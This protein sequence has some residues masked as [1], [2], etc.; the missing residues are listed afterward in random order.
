MAKEIERKFLLDVDKLPSRVI[1]ILYNTKP[2]H[3]EQFYTSINPEI[4][5]R[6]EVVGYEDKRKFTKTEKTKTSKA[7]VRKEKESKISEEEYYDQLNK[8]ETEI[9][10]AVITKNRYMLALENDLWA[11]IDIYSEGAYCVI[12]V[13]FSSVDEA[14]SWIPIDWFGEE[15]TSREEYKNVNIAIRLSER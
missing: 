5:Y 3:I 9:I 7:A 15:V 8:K 1:A 6:K 2:I 14:I 11:A 4:R 10:G 12:E 13:E